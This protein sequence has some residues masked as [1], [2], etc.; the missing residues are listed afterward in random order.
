MV[1][2]PAGEGPEFLRRL[3]GDARLLVLFDGR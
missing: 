3:L 2:L 1:A